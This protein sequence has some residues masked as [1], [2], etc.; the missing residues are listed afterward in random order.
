MTSQRRRATSPDLNQALGHA[1]SDKRIEILRRLAEA[2]SISQ[3]AR[4]TGISY[5]AAWQAIE[6]LGNLS[7]TP[8]V[9]KAVGGAGGGGARLTAAGRQVLAGAELHAQAR[10]GLMVALQ[11]RAGEPVSAGV[12]ALGLRTSM[13]NHLPC[14]VLRLQRTAG[15]VR[16]HLDLGDGLG[17]AARITSESAQLLGL[18][19]G[20]AVLALCKATGVQL[21][22]ALAPREGANLLQGLVTRCSRSAAGGEVSLRLGSGQQL[23]GFGGPGHGLKPGRMAR[24]LVDESAVVVA[25]TD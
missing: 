2:G 12:A 25:R 24:A 6:T 9:E 23:V 15:M 4:Q 18:V 3:A 10:R 22:A 20:L 13:R 5:K 19:P 14:R 16:V 8:M 21:A 11:G 7:G 17:M 1:A